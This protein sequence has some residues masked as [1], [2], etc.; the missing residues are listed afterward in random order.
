[1]QTTK[2][3]FIFFAC[4][5]F[6]FKIIISYCSKRNWI[7]NA[8]TLKCELNP[9]TSQRLLSLLASSIISYLFY[10]TSLVLQHLPTLQSI[11]W[12]DLLF[13]ILK[14]AW[15]LIWDGSL[16]HM[17]HSS[18]TSNFFP[19]EMRSWRKRVFFY[20]FFKMINDE[21]I[22]KRLWSFHSCLSSF[23]Y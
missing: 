10:S 8:L 23:N 15:H 19:Q 9:L 2:I 20:F 21:L 7:W 22:L 13:F 11:K 18:R 1:M 4:L 5:L 14:I 3:H 17:I 16:L 12:R 6:I